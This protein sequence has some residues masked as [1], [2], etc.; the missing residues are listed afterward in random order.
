MEDSKIRRLRQNQLKVENN[1]NVFTPRLAIKA[2]LNEAKR[3][4]YGLNNKNE[5][6]DILLS[7]IVNKLN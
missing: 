7:K 2:K 3:K 5:V 6:I 1:Y 4:H